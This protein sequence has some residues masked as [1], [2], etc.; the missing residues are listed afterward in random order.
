MPVEEV[1]PMLPVS[2]VRPVSTLRPVPVRPSSASGRDPDR[3]SS[4]LWGVLAEPY[5]AILDHPFV[6]GLADGTLSEAAFAHFLAQDARYLHDYAQALA[7]LA[8]RAG[9]LGDTAILARHAAGTA[10]VELALHAELLDAAGIDA[11]TLDG[12]AASPTTHGYTRHLL[13]TVLLGSFADGVAAIVPCFWLYA[14]VGEVL[15]SAGSP[16]PRYQRWLETYAGEDFGAV[17]VEVLDLV[18]RLGPGLTEPQRQH[19]EHET[20]TSARYEWMFFDA[21]LRQEGWPL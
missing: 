1:G 5:A 4:R 20:L 7:L 11:A 3:W 13:S 16:D 21:A 15:L 17:V 12:I 19:A 6:T 8:G 2:P 10:E 9:D 14:R 18:D